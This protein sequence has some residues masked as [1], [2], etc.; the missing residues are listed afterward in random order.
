MNGIIND[1]IKSK[2]KAI[3]LQI[4]DYAQCF[5]SLSLEECCNSLFD[6]GIRNDN[7]SLIYKANETNTVAVKTPF[8]LT[9]K[10]KVNRIVL[11]GDVWGPLQC[12]VL[13]D[14]IG[15]EC[16]EE[17]KLL[18]NYKGNVKIP[19][20]AMVDDIVAV[21]E[22]GMDTVDINSYLNTKTNLKKLQ[23]GA[24]KCYK[25][26]VGCDKNF[27]PDLTID[28]WK[29]VKVDEAQCGVRNLEDVPDG[30]HIME[31]SEEQKYL[32]D[33]ISSKGCNKSNIM[34]RRSKGLGIVK[35]ISTILEET[36]FG[37]YKV[38]VAMILRNSLFINSIMCNSEV[39]YNV[40]LKDIECLEQ[41]DEMLLRKIIACPRTT[42]RPMLYLDMGC[43]PLR[44]VVKT[45]RLMFLH[46]VLNESESSLIHSFFKAQVESPVKGDWYH[47]IIEDMRDLSLDNLTFEDIKNQS[48]SQ[49]KN[50]V[51]SAAKSHALTYLLNMKKDMSKVA[52]INY[53]ELK[54]QNYLQSE[55]FSSRQSSFLFNA[56]CRMLDVRSNY[57]GSYKDHN[58]PVCLDPFVEDSQSHLLT[59]SKLQGQPIT[60]DPVRYEDIFDPNPLNQLKIT[61]TLM[62]KMEAR[63]NLIGSTS[64]V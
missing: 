9:T 16:L 33:I 12:S 44:Y 48:K 51:N 8:G 54:L 19:P 32:G 37:Y 20:L 64:Q 45:R 11:Q 59:C 24:K 34:A 31:I 27:C 39:W 30:D 36:A 17:N 43:L 3:D 1:V 47:H 13:V 63:N 15:K 58:C 41:I 52:H 40:T 38:E 14:S 28:K 55:L 62:K 25:M 4:L 57:R 42:P 2:N 26:H 61:Q 56:R 7:L 49:F 23:F 53:S 35:Q 29:L 46:Y 6:A 60:G 22:C 18:Y 50:R 10:E 5:D 21:S